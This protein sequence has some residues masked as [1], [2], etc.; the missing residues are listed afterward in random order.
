M[1]N[2]VGCPRLN[3]FF[4]EDLSYFYK[5][6]AISFFH[7][8]VFDGRLGWFGLLWSYWWFGYKNGISND[9]MGII[10]FQDIRG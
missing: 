10:F 5:V 7:C 4:R 2:F 9:R 3:F 1:W 8:V 6:I